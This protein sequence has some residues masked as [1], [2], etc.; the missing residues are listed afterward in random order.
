MYTFRLLF[1]FLNYIT[2]SAAALFLLAIF[3]SS[4]VSVLMSLATYSPS[5]SFSLSA[6]FNLFCR[7][8]LNFRCFR[9]SS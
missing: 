7:K 9:I 6:V 3:C 1:S 5:S 4:I 2:S 8:S